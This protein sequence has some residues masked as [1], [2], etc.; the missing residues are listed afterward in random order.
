[1]S[2]NPNLQSRWQQAFDLPDDKKL[3]FTGFVISISPADVIISLESL[4]KSIGLLRM[5]YQVA[6]TLG[7][8]LNQSIEGFETDTGYTFT[9]LDEMEK[10]ITKLNKKSE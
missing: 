5:P 8:K 1:M 2:E 7:Q 6:K 3:Y 4:G 10:I 9:S